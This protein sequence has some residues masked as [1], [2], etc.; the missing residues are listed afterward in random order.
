MELASFGTEIADLMAKTKTP[1]WAVFKQRA[2]RKRPSAK[3]E[4]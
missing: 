2:P 4:K 3:K 1:F